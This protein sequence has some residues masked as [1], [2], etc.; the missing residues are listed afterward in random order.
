MMELVHPSDCQSGT[1]G[2]GVPC[3][4]TRAVEVPS[5]LIMVRGTCRCESCDVTSSTPERRRETK[6]KVKKAQGNEWRR[7]HTD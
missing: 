3:G 2:W 1:R 6:E 7:N 5:G 4:N